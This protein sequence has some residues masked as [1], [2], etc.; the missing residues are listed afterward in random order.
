MKSLGIIFE[1]RAAA[2]LRAQDLE[3]IAQ[4]YRCREGEIDLI[5]SDHSTLVFVEVKQ[6]SSDRFGSAAA[7]VTQ[8]KLSRLYRTAERFLQKHPEFSHMRA[9]FDIVAFQS[10]DPTPKWLKSVFTPS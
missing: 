2:Y 4:N 6:R 9:R 8:K 10:A 1:A 7:T 3:L 5:M